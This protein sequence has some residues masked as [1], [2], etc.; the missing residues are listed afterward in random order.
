MGHLEAEI[1][2]VYKRSC[3]RWVISEITSNRHNAQLRAPY[4]VHDC[5]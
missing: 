2:A 5:W 3:F 4:S 1:F